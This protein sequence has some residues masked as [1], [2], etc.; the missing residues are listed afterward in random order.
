MDTNSPNNDL[1]IFAEEVNKRVNV[2]VAEVD[3]FLSLW[4]IREYKRNELILR[5][6]MIPAFS[7]FVLNGCLRQYVVSDEGRESV[8]YFA[9]E[10]HFI[11]DLPALRNK[12]PS[13]F[14]FQ[15]I[16]PCRV[17]VLTKDN[18]EQSSIRFPWW[19]EAHIKGYQ[20]WA[21]NMQQ[22]IADMQL[23][24]GEE[25]YLELLKRRPALFQRVPQHYIASY[26]GLTPE[27]LSRIRKKLTN[28]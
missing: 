2:S 21:I 25:R 19:M 23:K 18:W 17:L 24:S 12:V 9:E 14:N 20:K 22:Q 15:A 6:G 1:V 7:M 4:E 28:G 8:V 26:L 16:E 5:A 13:D 11:G 10:R 3:Q 27:T